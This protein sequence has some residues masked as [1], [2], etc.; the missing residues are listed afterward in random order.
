MAMCPFPLE[1][2]QFWPGQTRA[3]KA[4]L[5]QG[6]AQP[7]TTVGT[8]VLLPLAVLETGQ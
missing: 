4:S 5:G 3:L 8:G 6:K 2:E 1:E 7:D